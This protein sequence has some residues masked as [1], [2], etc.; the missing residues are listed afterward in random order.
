MFAGGCG[1]PSCVFLLYQSM[2]VL[3]FEGGVFK[4]AD[5]ILTHVIVGVSHLGIQYAYSGSVF[6]TSQHEVG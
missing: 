6:L 1:R 5:H 3:P 4:R 2:G